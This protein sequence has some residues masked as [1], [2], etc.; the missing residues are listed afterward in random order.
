MADYS[1]KIDINEDSGVVVANVRER[2][3]SGEWDVVDSQTFDPAAVAE[4][5]QGFVNGYGLSKLMQDRSSAVPTGPDKLAAMNEVFAMLCEGK[6]R[7]ERTRGAAV[8]SA[9]VEALAEIKGVDIPTIQKSL[10]KYTEE[11]RKEILSH[12]KVKAKAEEIRNRRD[13]TEEVDLESL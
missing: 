3:E 9:E 11:K 2:D 13:S 4:S 8:V 7:A 12:P 5:A 10:K 1:M 6:L